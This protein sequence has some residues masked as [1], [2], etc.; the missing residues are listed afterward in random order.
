MKF[1]YKLKDVLLIAIIALLFGVI[2]LGC[3]HGGAFLC[4]L[5][6]PFGLTKL[7][8]EPFY[9]IWFMAGA[10]AAFIMRKPG[11]GVIAEILAA[12]LETLFGNFFGPIV[13]LSGLVQ[14]IGIELLIAILGYKNYKMGIMIL[15]AV[16]CSVLTMGYNLVVSGYNAIAP[17]VLCL[18]LAVRLVSAILF[19]GILT[20]ILCKGLAK[21][22]V[23]K[24]YAVAQ[25]INTD[26]EV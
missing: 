1:E 9:G 12:I 21:A 6:T 24:G 26:L 20:P 19:C 2:Y 4:G 14:G 25:D 15:C 16:I 23:L 13:I 3:V 17:G 11:C 5:L 8:Y 22:G 10:V 18:M 7:G